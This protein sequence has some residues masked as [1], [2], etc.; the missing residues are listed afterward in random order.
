MWRKAFCRI[1]LYANGIDCGRKRGFRYNNNITLPKSFDKWA[2][3]VR[4]FIRFI[5]DR[6]GREEIETWYF[7]VWNEPDLPIFLMVNSGITSNY[8]SIR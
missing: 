1:V 7:E 6:Y 5:E 4:R 8:M 2:E 3:H